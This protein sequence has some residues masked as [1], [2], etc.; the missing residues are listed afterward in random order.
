MQDDT[1]ADMLVMNFSW[2]VPGRL[3]GCRGPQ[4]EEQLGWLAAWGV[5]ALVRLAFDFETDMDSDRVRRAGLRECYEPVSDYG[6]PDQGQIDRVVGFLR[7]RIAAGEPVAVSCRAG[8]GRTGTILASYF[9]AE[10]RSGQDALDH[11]I[12]LRPCC[13]EVR[14]APDQQD[15]ILEFARRVQLGEWSPR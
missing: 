3:A 6:A 11:L 1:A 12:M 14:W 13:R 15:A 4:S 9:A 7:E 2:V 10:G 8:C 5:T